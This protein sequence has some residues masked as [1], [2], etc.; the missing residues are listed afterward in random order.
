MCTAHCRDD[1]ACRHR[2]YRLRQTI[3]ATKYY[4]ETT[5]TTKNFFTWKAHQ[6]SIGS[7]ALR[8]IVVTAVCF[9]RFF[10]R[11]LAIRSFVVRES[12]CHKKFCLR[13]V[14]S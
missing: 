1:D 12:A 11:G 10:V 3:S 5:F 14:L 9:R 13:E 7:L 4:S 2:L 8:G 6:I